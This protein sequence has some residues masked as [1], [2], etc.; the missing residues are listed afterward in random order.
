MCGTKA[1]DVK[2]SVVDKLS[3]LSFENVDGTRPTTLWSGSATVDVQRHHNTAAP[4][5]TVSV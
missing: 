2:K 5:S 4:S 1:S 3:I